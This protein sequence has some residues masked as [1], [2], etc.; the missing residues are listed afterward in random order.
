MNAMSLMPT[1]SGGRLLA[2]AGFANAFRRRA[3][4][5]LAKQLGASSSTVLTTKLGIRGSSAATTL[6]KR[7]LRWTKWF[8]FSEN[9][10]PSTRYVFSDGTALS[11]TRPSLRNIKHPL[12]WVE[13]GIEDF[14]FGTTG[15]GCEPGAGCVLALVASI[16]IPRIKFPNS[17]SFVGPEEGTPALVASIPPAPPPP[18][19]SAWVMPVT[20]AA[21]SFT[22]KSDGAGPACIKVAFC[23]PLT[24]N[25]AIRPLAILAMA[26]SIM[27]NSPGT[28]I[29]SSRMAAP[30]GGTLAVWTPMSGGDIREPSV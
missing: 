23:G 20:Q 14:E 11:I 6:P 10:M 17:L 9:T 18:T 1:V 21:D 13:L 25:T 2:P 8:A 26:W 15:M 16:A 19:V 22:E 30:P 27:V 3:G 4:V 24:S 28:L 29:E 7:P 12:S 5:T